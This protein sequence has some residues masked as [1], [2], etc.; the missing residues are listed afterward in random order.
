MKKRYIITF[1]SSLLIMLFI[2]N[3]NAKAEFNATN[4]IIYDVDYEIG[5]TN[6]IGQSM[7]G[8][9]FDEHAYL[10]KEDDLYFVSINLLDNSAISDIDISL[11]N[12]KSG[13]L[14]NENGKKTTYTITIGEEDITSS[15]AIKGKVSAMNKDVSFTIKLN[16]DNMVETNEAVDKSFE[17]PA[18]FVPEII[19]DAL[20]DVTSIQNATYKLPS[21]RAMFADE[22]CKLEI[23]VKSPSGDS[24]NVEENKIVL[25]ELGEY[26]V[27]Y[28]ASTPKYKTNLGNDSYITKSFKVISTSAGSSLVKVLDN[29]KILPLNYVVQSQRIESGE[30]YTNIANMLVKKSERYEIT[31]VLLLDNNGESL[32]INSNVS[33]YI[34][35][36][37][38][39][40][41]NDVRVYHLNK[42]NTLEEIKASGYGRY[43]TF[44]TNYTG[45]FIVLIPGV[46]F[47]MPMWGYALIAIGVVVL[48]GLIVFLL[49][50]FLKK[51]HKKLSV[52]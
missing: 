23:S 31:N 32:E 47:V 17:Y 2:M 41:R 14:T 48:I 50:Y 15:I 39:Y 27:V 35:T 6:S 22:E 46:S 26:E 37:P 9:Y 1:I 18:R 40:N 19:I 28:K 30:D 24:V 44:E 49:V 34:Q 38:N 4:D 33:Y 42:D 51:R 7:I 5:G 3:I 12:Y 13:I 8:K 10:L 36:N 52:E 21:A 29:N 43:I 45:T 25:T 20:G 11:G 16:L